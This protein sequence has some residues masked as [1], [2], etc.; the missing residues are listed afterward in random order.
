MADTENKET[1]QEPEQKAEPE[2]KQDK[3][4]ETESKPAET[5]TGNQ[6]DLL[7]EFKSLKQE[8]IDYVDLKFAN[9]PIAKDEPAKDE[10]PKE[11]KLPV[12]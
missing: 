8:L 1:K 7:K 10:E 5:E 6:V 12:W 9:A 2:Q 4:V 3:T 11:K